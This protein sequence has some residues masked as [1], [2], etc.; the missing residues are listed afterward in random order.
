VHVLKDGKGA[1]PMRA[2]GLLICATLAVAACGISAGSAAPSHGATQ[3][4][5]A[6]DM[7]SAEARSTPTA[8]AASTAADLVGGWD[9]VA[10][11]PDPALAVRGDSTPTLS[12]GPYG[13]LAGFTGCNSFSGAYTAADDGTMVIDTPNATTMLACDQGATAVETAYLAALAKVAAFRLEAGSDGTVLTLSGPDGGALLGY[14]AASVLTGAA[15]LARSISFDGVEDRP[16]EGTAPSLRLGSDGTA[17][18]DTGCNTFSGTYTSTATALSFGPLATTMKACAGELQSR[19]E[20]E[21][22]ADLAATAAY[23]V[24]AA[25]TLTLIGADGR[26][27]VVFGPRW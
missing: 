24:D 8:I 27:L 23:N 4:P 17:G 11:H 25:G 9:L 15:W 21:Y 13:A 14:R 10:F 18:G 16:L 22:L 26:A 20:D 19:Q 7:P 2:L 12:F 6:S 3:A 1:P 5:P